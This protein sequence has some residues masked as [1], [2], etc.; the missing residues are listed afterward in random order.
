MENGNNFKPPYEKR[1]TR[2]DIGNPKRLQCEAIGGTWDEESQT[3]IYKEYD[4]SKGLLNQPEVEKSPPIPKG[5]EAL[6]LPK[7]EGEKIPTP[8]K[9]KQTEPEI[10]TDETGKPTGVI[11][12]DGR[13]FFGL[14]TTEVTNIVNQYNEQRTLPQGSSLVGSA[15]NRREVARQAQLLGGQ[16]G[17]FQQLGVAASEFDE[18]RALRDTA[19][20]AIP[21]ALGA[22][23]LLETFGR[24]SATP[25]A[26][27]GGGRRAL[28]TNPRA[29]GTNPRAVRA[30]AQAGG[31]ATV[32]KANPYLLV[33]TIAAALVS[34]FVSSYKEQR[35]EMAE[36]PNMVL[37]DGKSNL[38]DAVSFAA[39]DPA[40][41]PLAVAQFNQ[42]L[43]LIDQAYRQLKLDNSRDILRFENNI[44]KVVDFEFFYSEGGER[45]QLRNMMFEAL[46]INPNDPMAVYLFQQMAQRRVNFGYDENI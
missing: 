32:A 24:G 18:L 45:D 42:Q 25:A 10:F 14:S 30:A 4:F 37:T 23:L 11:L 20:R 33:G 43:A 9:L 6:K 2:K 16:V 34:S 41:R 26:V 12:P 38:M 19:L 36:N 40:N 5:G 39:G 15:G 17:Q 22:G 8:P 13:E 21:Q 1:G 7:G 31:I 28:G 46:Q 44:D 29:L 27:G 3:C 35:R